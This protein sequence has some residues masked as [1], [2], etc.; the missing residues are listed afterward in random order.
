MLFQ[1]FHE[2]IG[3]LPV[4]LLQFGVETGEPLFGGLVGRLLVGPLELLPPF[5][6]VGLRQV[7][8]HVFPLVPLA[9]LDF[10]AA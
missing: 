9:A 6:L 10:G 7:T 1:S 8:D 2:G 3:G 5:F 4:D